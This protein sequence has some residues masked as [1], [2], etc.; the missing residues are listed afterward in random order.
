ML[1]MKELCFP[2]IVIVGQDPNKRD[3]C[4]VPDGDVSRN[5]TGLLDL[6]G[7]LSK[8]NLTHDE[9]ESALVAHMRFWDRL[10]EYYRGELA[11]L[12][13]ISA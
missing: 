7:K 9:W 11:D 4:Y 6:E 3:Y 8:E 2:E 12:T 5:L 1:A 13:A 10:P